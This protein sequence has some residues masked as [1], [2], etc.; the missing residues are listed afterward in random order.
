MMTLPFGFFAS[1][2]RPADIILIDT[3]S[4]HANVSLVR[5]AAAW[6]LNASQ[7]LT[8]VTSNVARYEYDGNGN[9]R[10]LMIEPNSIRRSAQADP[11]FASYNV[12]IGI[13]VASSAIAS[14]FANSSQ[15]PASPSGINIGAV[16]MGTV[17][18][19]ADYTASIFV[20]M[21]DNSAP[22]VGAN[23]STGDFCITMFGAGTAVNIIPPPYTVENYGGGVYRVSATA[24]AP[25]SAT[26][27][28]GIAQHPTQSGKA[29]RITGFNNVNQSFLTSYI[30]GNGSQNVNR[31]VDTVSVTLAGSGISTTQGTFYIE[32]DGASGVALLSSGVN[33]T[34]NS[35]GAGKTA[36][37]YDAS[38]SSICTN[39]G[40]VTTGSALI[41]STAVRLGMSTGSIGSNIRVK[42]WTWH[43]T[44]LSAAELQTLTA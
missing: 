38:G 17:T 42:K 4:K 12:K 26:L 43:N 21:G 34:L 8:Q 33:A 30:S 15:F 40:A 31:S 3:N 37:S 25:S 18:A 2:V 35:A 39:G 24:T 20:R 5:T 44:K 1:G 16:Y 22:V 36:I 29:F 9:Y 11:I 6:Y 41:F 19:G 7:V 10:G 32:H 23:N 14:Y 13:S 28:F 27:N